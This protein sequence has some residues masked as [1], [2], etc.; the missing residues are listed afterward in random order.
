MVPQRFSS[1][2]I[3]PLISPPELSVK[4]FPP[5]AVFVPAMRP[6]RALLVTVLPVTSD[7]PL[8]PMKMPCPPLPWTEFPVTVH[9]SL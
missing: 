5:Y 8:A 6:F 2:S 4:I 9:R 3:P 7:F 1:I